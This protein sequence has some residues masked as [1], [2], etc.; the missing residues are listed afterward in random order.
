MINL[1]LQR[2][3]SILNTLSYFR[4][5]FLDLHDQGQVV[6]TGHWQAL[7]GVPHTKTYE[8]QNV[9]IEMPI[10]STVGSWQSWI[11]PNLP[12]AEDHFQE[13]V[14]GEPLNP[15]EQYKNW[16]WYRGGVETHK[17]QGLFSH[18]Y[19]ERFWPKQAGVL[20]HVGTNYGIRF[21]YGDLGDLLSLL[22]RDPF[23][24][25]AYLPIWFPEDLTASIENQ[26]VPCSIGYHFM[27]R[28]D[29]LYC[30]YMIRSCDFIRYFQDDAYM[31]GR[32]V[33]WI[34]QQL[35]WDE[36]SPG[37]LTMVI[38]SLHIFEGDIPKLK[39]ESSSAATA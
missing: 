29:R 21:R 13:R 18:T 33:Q 36:A 3:Q 22:R 6:D 20:H 14:G 7:R 4:E 19:M 27:L 26:R 34:L 30:T 31:A 16:P 35:G 37:L 24:R 38:P 5:R 1:R 8:L 39:R 9:V 28:D 32:L 23:T 15:G 25:Q 17:P 12:W 10:M 2:E 11:R